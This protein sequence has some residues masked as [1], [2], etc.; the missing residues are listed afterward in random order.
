MSY[1]T[2]R[3]LPTAVAV[4]RKM[5]HLRNGRRDDR[6][7]LHLLA[8]LVERLFHA[9]LLDGEEHVGHVVAEARLRAGYA[10]VAEVEV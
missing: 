10:R 7:L 1:A 2:E 5:L 6:G 8:S 3:I 4:H 9:R